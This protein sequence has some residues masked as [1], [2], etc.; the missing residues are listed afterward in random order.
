M[1]EKKTQSD[2][3][4]YICFCCRNNFNQILVYDNYKSVVTFISAIVWK[5]LSDLGPF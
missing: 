2:Y 3:S 5:H 4:S 1:V